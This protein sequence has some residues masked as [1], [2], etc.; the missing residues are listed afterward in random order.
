MGPVGG[1]GAPTRMQ[2]HRYAPPTSLGPQAGTDLLC[3]SVDAHRA[4]TLT[5]PSKG[6][7]RAPRPSTS[8]SDL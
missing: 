7:S 4:A 6:L 5:L 1:G 8:S 3:S 2:R